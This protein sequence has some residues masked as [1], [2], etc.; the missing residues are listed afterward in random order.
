[1]KLQHLFESDTP[2]KFTEASAEDF[3]KAI[4][5]AKK[6]MKSSNKSKGMDVLTDYSLSDYKKYKTYLSNDG[7][8]GYMVKSDGDLVSVFSLVSGRGNSIMQSA[9]ANGAKKLDF[10]ATQDKNGKLSG[11]L[12]DLYSR[13][14]F[15]VNTAHN[16][17]GEYPV[18]N[19]LSPVA[20]TNQVV[21]YM[22]RGN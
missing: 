15:K 10:F 14:G 16:E 11:H 2:L 20:G 8:S 3:N 18:K 22:K 9:I 19:G 17:G 13:H 7:K 21:V 12:Y 5:E 4:N 6:N 1:M